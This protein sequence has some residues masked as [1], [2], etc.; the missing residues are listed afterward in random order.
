MSATVISSFEQ[1]EPKTWNLRDVYSD[2]TEKLLKDNP[3][4][5]GRWSVSARQRNYWIY[6]KV[7]TSVVEVINYERWKNIVRG[8]FLEARKCI[9]D[10]EVLTMGRIG[11][12]EAKCVERNH[13]NLQVDWGETRL[14]PKVMN[15][16][17][18][19]VPQT[20]IYYTD[21]HWL[22]IGWRKGKVSNILFYK[23][24]ATDGNASKKGFKQEFAD[25]NRV[26]PELRHVYRQ[27]SYIS[28][29][30]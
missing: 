13:N 17:G 18:K 29:Q 4:Y 23:F 2:F 15:A 14:Q 11:R 20:I 16:K 24:S 12:I 26:N 21:D 27:C 19:M 6:T 7:G 10:G 3:E 8:Y 22:R 5:W 30:E 1:Q 28:K 25:A 9:I